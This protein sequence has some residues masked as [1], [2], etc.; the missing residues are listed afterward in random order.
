MTDKQG[1]S[2]ETNVSLFNQGVRTNPCFHEI[3]ICIKLKAP[4]I[5]HQHWSHYYRTPFFV[6]HTYWWLLTRV[7]ILYRIKLYFTVIDVSLCMALQPLFGP[8]LLV[9]QL[10][11][12]HTL[13]IYLIA[14]VKNVNNFVFMSSCGKYSLLTSLLLIWEKTTPCSQYLPHSRLP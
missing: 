1:M 7:H 4:A 13:L 12:C 8:V 14:A 3:F 10:Y 9:A 5:L 6:L 2:N 11:G